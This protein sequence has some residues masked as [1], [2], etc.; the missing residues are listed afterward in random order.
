MNGT[1]NY[2]KI[3]ARDVAVNEYSESEEYNI[4]IGS[5]ITP[6]DGIGEKGLLDYWWLIVLVIIILILVIIT[7]FNRK[8]KPQLG[9]EH[10]QKPSSDYL[11]IENNK[12]E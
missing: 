11:Y 2:I 4:Q 1:D 8:R 5:G 9:P 6:G 7:I 12:S 10:E 3:R